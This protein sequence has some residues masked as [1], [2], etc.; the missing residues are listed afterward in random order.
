MQTRSHCFVVV[1]V[2]LAAC[3]RTAVTTSPT[4][5]VTTSSATSSSIPA[6]TV[7]ATS[8]PARAVSSANSDGAVAVIDGFGLQLARR[9]LGLDRGN[10]A[11]SP[12][13][14]ATA[15]TMTSAGA[16]GDTAAEMNRV[17]GIADPAT[18]HESMNTFDQSVAASQVEPKAD[19]ERSIELA[20]ANRAFVQNDLAMEQP[21]LNTL[22]SQYGSD[23]GPVNFRGNQ[24]AARTTINGWVND[25]TKAH[26]PELIGKGIITEDTRL[27]LVNALYLKANWAIPFATAVPGRFNTPTG[28]VQVPM[29]G[30]TH[31]GQIAA[32]DGWRAV[33]LPYVGD[34]L[35]MT[36]VLPDEG[37]FDAVVGQLDA[38]HMAAMRSA[39]EGPVADLKMP[40]FDIAKNIRLDNQLK[41][42]GMN[43]AFSGAAD[44]SGMTTSERLQIQTVI[45]QATVTVNE[46]GTVATAATAMLAFPVSAPPTTP[47]LVDRP[48]LFFISDHTT[49]AV[50]FVG[51][52]IDP[53]TS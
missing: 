38:M 18:I 31:R 23:V 17:L 48:F 34:R 11:L 37:K 26:I 9:G 1:L 35:S 36:I 47:F 12:L 5:S 44:F 46:N 33:D 13:S 28:A 30:D 10:S 40:K 25:R 45:H 14:V 2:I 4:S 41:A 22:A 16:R 43:V 52:V 27:A 29:M 39:N 15:L 19:D 51:Q 6:T 7:L 50:L 32:G 42:L 49:D 3:S 21:F 53:T 20:T 8:A 24:E